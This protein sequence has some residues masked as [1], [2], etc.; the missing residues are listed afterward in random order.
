MTYCALVRNGSC[1]DLTESNEMIR[2]A[3]RV[4]ELPPAALALKQGYLSCDTLVHGVFRLTLL[5]LPRQLVETWH[6]AA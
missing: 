1:L 4:Y 2:S 3:Y 6:V 5:F